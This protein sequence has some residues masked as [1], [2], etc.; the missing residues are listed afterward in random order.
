MSARPG[1]PAPLP[2]AAPAR[3]HVA[4]AVVVVVLLVAGLLSGGWMLGRAQLPAASLAPARWA[5]G[6]AGRAINQALKLPLQAQADLAGAALRYRLLGDAGPQV[7]LGCPGWLFYRD[8]LR[9]PAGVGEAVFAQRVRLMRHWARQ[10]QAQ[11]V[12]LLVV[13]VPDKAR[14]EQAHTCGLRHSAPMRARLEQWQQALAA[15]GVASTDL[16][17]V[18]QAGQEPVF[19][20]TDVHMNRIGAQRAAD[21]V[22]ASALP[23]LGGRGGQAFEVGAPGAPKP[24]MGD[25]IVLAGLEHAPPAW[26]PALDREPEQ[27]IA[28]LRSGGLLDDTPPVEVLL[29]GSSNGRRSLFAERLGHALGREVWN[30]SLDGGQFS[31][32]LLAAWPQRAQWPPSLKLVVWEFSEMAL[33]LPLTD[34]ERA[35]LAE[36]D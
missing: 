16:L 4:T 19:F 27:A 9:P 21:A 15:A 2:A 25:L 3:A 35:A 28:P 1:A 14:I 7:A 34:G 12:Q 36:T 26:R 8:G 11:G 33:S 29:L 32:A 30:Q 20:R 13:A 24:R 31:G 6:E 17:P 22:A 23:L 10:L 18:L 5:D